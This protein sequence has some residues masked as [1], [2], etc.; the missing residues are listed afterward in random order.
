MHGMPHHFNGMH[1][2]HTGKNGCLSMEPDSTVNFFHPSNQSRIYPQCPTPTQ[3]YSCYY[4][5][6]AEEEIKK[7]LS[8]KP[9]PVYPPTPEKFHPPASPMKRPEHLNN[10]TVN[11]S[12]QHH[13]ASPMKRSEHLN[14]CPLN[15]SPQHHHA[16]F[17]DPNEKSNE[18]ISA[19]NTVQHHPTYH[20][21]NQSWPIQPVNQLAHPVP[22]HMHP[23]HHQQPP[24]PPMTSFGY[25]NGQPNEYQETHFAHHGPNMNGPQVNAS[26]FNELYNHQQ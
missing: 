19:F 1:E 14:D 6:H 25:H 3:P 2:H 24:Y 8:P 22:P 9:E 13:Q 18:E 16:S 15:A 4:S 11:Q 20:N 5:E 21:N 12:P 17:H 23:H 26:G 7:V 10:C